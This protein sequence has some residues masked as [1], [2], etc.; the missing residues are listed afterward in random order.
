MSSLVEQIKVSGAYGALRATKNRLAW[1]FFERGL[2]E[3][4]GIVAADQLGFDHPE[5]MRYEAS[6]WTWLRRALR[7]RK[8]KSDDVFV[9][10]GSGKGRVVW[11]AAQYRFARVVGVEI[12]PQLNDVARRNIEGGRKRLKC[13][14][15]ELVTADATEFEVPDDMTVAYFY[16]PFEGDV[17]RQVLR[18]IVESVDRRP[19]KV[20]MIYANPVLADEVEAVGRFELVDVIKGLR[21]DTDDSSWVNL[22]EIAPAA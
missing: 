15:V 3:T 2:E 5:H 22:Y 10:F 14:D 17:F 16:S 9:D 11:Q 19:R 21:P 4:N 18:N 13:G 7:R 20:T 1:L 12:S 6:S 8:V